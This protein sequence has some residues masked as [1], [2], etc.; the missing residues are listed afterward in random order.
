[1][2]AVTR[3]F[4][5]GELLGPKDLQSIYAL[6]LKT[7]EIAADPLHPYV[8]SVKA[9][10]LSVYRSMCLEY[11]K[12]LK[13]Q[14]TSPARG[15]EVAGVLERLGF[16]AAFP[17]D[18][19]FCEL[20]GSCGEYDLRVEVR[21]YVERDAA[22]LRRR[23]GEDDGLARELRREGASPFEAYRRQKQLREDEETLDERYMFKHGGYYLTA[24]QNA[25]YR[26]AF[27]EQLRAERKARSAGETFDF[28]AE[29]TDIVPFIVE[30]RNAATGQTLRA[31]GQLV[32]L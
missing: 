26:A 30:M 31:E 2:R 11:E 3:R 20:R 21:G 7:R 14:L 24:A 25:Y 27:N 6:Y 16:V 28:T 15:A 10:N 19:A 22:S 12:N 5:A 18:E 32:D 9:I 1:M 17:A 8:Q 29:F 13:P 4:S 23:R